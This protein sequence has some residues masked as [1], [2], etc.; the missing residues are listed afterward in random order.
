[1]GAPRK[2][3]TI[4]PVKIR[5]EE[6]LATTSELNFAPGRVTCRREARGKGYRAATQVKGLSPEMFIVP[7]AD[8]F[9]I[10]GKQNSRSRYRQDYRSPAGSKAVA[11]YQ[12][13]SI[14]TREAQYVPDRVCT[15]KP[16]IR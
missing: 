13:D 15:A 2:A 9:H 7:A 11:R 6:R 8:V 4:K 16:N 10:C 3:Y 14:G 5:S 12:T 1:M